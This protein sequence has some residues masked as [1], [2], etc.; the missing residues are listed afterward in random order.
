MLP[1]RST[2]LYNSLFPQPKKRFV[3]TDIPIFVTFNKYYGDYHIIIK[4]NPAWLSVFKGTVEV[5]KHGEIVS[6]DIR[7]ALRIINEHMK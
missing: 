1:D 6:E 3:A 2:R 7:E 4:R 5:R